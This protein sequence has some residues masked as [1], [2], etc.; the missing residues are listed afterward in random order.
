ML[1]IHHIQ[2]VSSMKPV[3][4]TGS[5]FDKF[6]D[7]KWIS[8]MYWKCSEAAALW[9]GRYNRNQ[10]LSNGKIETWRFSNINWPQDW[11][12]FRFWYQPS[13]LKRVNR[14]KIFYRNKISLFIRRSWKWCHCPVQFRFCQKMGCKL[15]VR[16]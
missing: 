8:M 6:K 4:E 9:E 1:H 13:F 10:I 15:Y 7:K 16:S 2:R 3:V 14:C 11:N 12:M 5:L